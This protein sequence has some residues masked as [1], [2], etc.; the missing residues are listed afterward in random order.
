MNSQF[1]RTAFNTIQTSYKTGMNALDQF[2][3]GKYEMLIPAMLN[4]CF[5]IEVAIKSIL[6]INNVSFKRTHHLGKLFNDLSGEYK[7]LIIDLVLKSNQ[8]GQVPM[9]SSKDDFYRDLNKNSSLYVDLRYFELEDKSI[10][11]KAN[12]ITLLSDIIVNMALRLINPN[13]IDKNESVHLL[14]KK[15]RENKKITI[16]ELAGKIGVHPTILEKY[17]SNLNNPS[18]KVLIK[19][20]DILDVKIDDLIDMKK[21]N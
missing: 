3:E 8:D 10:Q 2:N 9:L 16:E 21:G 6:N 20:S 5:S 12:F 1:K 17:E 11:F 15:H 19:I 18:F 7:A 4:L 14:I 13:Y